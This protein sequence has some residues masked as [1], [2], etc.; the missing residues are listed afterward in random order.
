MK[1]E[2]FVCLGLLNMGNNLCNIGLIRYLSTKYKIVTVAV[3]EKY[4]ESIK[5]L[6]QDNKKIN[7]IVFKN[8]EE[9]IPKYGSNKINKYSKFMDIYL[10]FI[11]QD[12]YIP[13]LQ[14]V[15]PFITYTELNLHPSIFWEYFSVPD[16]ENSN[17]LYQLV[18]NMD[19]AFVHTN[20]SLG[21]L[22]NTEDIEKHLNISKN[23]ILIIDPN[24]N[25]YDKNHKF[26]DLANQFIFKPTIL[27]YK[28][29]IMK[30]NR[31]LLTD[32]SFF[33]L[34]CQLELNC[35]EPLLYLRDRSELF[36]KRYID[37]LNHKYL[38]EGLKRTK[39]K[40]IE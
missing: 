22:L 37:F 31:L 11:Y 21:K 15:I 24:I 5:E 4:Y 36:Y 23:D 12:K 16:T 10:D 29:T 1:S 25:H 8:L 6:Y 40:I 14:K 33:C 18:E 3:L 39:F 9:I 7:F 20:F 17:K 38:K 28:K 27:T 34:A 35:K 30:T 19:Y 26:Y 13:K 32:S 2:A